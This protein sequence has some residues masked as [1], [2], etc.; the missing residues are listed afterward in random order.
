MSRQ[1]VAGELGHGIAVLAIM[2]AAASNTV[3]KAGIAVA[4]GGWRFG[5]D[6]ALVFAGALAAGLAVALAL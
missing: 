2:L 6:V 1:W 4:T 5:R 3:V